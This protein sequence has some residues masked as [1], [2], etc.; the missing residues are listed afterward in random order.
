MTDMALGSLSGTLETLQTLKDI[1]LKFSQYS[2][3][4]FLNFL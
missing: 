4:L 1:S 2:R 3:S